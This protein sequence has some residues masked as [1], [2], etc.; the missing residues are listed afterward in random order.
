MDDVSGAGPGEKIYDYLDDID[1]GLWDDSNGNRGT[2]FNNAV[3]TN[4]GKLGKGFEFD[5][6][7]DYINILDSPS[8]DFNK[9]FTIALWVKFKGL[10]GD[11]A[12]I[13]KWIGGGDQRSWSFWND[14]ANE[15]ELRFLANEDGG[16]FGFYQIA[17]TNADL[18]NNTWYH[19]AVTWNLTETLLY[20][21][22]VELITSET[23]TRPSSL[24]VSIANV[25]IAGTELGYSNNLNS[26][27]DDVM[28]FNRSLSPA[29]IQALYADNVVKNYLNDFQN[30]VDG[31]YRFNAYAQDLAGNIG[32]ETER[33]VTIDTISPTTIINS[34][35]ASSIQN[36]DFDV[37][38]TD[39]D[40]IG[41]SGID[42]N[43]CYYRILDDG[44][45]SLGWTTRTCSGLLTI[46]INSYCTTLGIDTCVVEAYAKDNAGNGGVG[47]NDVSRSFSIDTSGDIID[48]IVVFNDLI[49]PLDNTII[50][51]S[52]F[53]V[54][55]DI[56]EVSLD[57]V[58]YS[59]DGIDYTVFNDSLV[60]M[61]N[62]DNVVSLG[63]SSSNVAELSGNGIDLSC[64]VCPIA[65]TGKFN[66]CY[67]YNG[68]INKRY[69]RTANID[70][71]DNF[72]AGT[73]S[74]WI[75]TTKTGFSTILEYGNPSVNNGFIHWAIND[76]GT[77]YQEW[78]GD[79]G[80][81]NN[82]HAD[83]TKP[84]AFIVDGK[85]HHI[86]FVADGIN[87]IKMYVDGLEISVNDLTANGVP[88]GTDSDWIADA[89]NVDSI[90]N[91]IEIGAFHYNSVSF[92]YFDGSI[93]EVRMYDRALSDSEIEVLYK[94]NLNKY[95]TDKWTFFINQDFGLTEGSHTFN[96]YA[97]DVA[98][99]LGSETERTI[100][101][102]TQS[103]VVNFQGLTPA[104]GFS[105]QNDNFVVDVNADDTG[106]GDNFIS[107]FINFDKSLVGWWRMDDVDGGGNPLDYTNNNDGTAYGDAVQTND[108][109]LGKGFDFDGT[110]DY[111]G[112]ADID[113]PTG[114]FSI[115]VWFKKV[116]P[117]GLIITKGISSVNQIFLHVT[118]LG[119]TGGVYD[120]SDWA[121]V[122]DNTISWSDGTWHHA[123]LV[124]DETNVIM[125]GDGLFLG[126]DSHDNS[127]PVND[128]VWEIG[129]RNFAGTVYF[130]G[131]IDD[132][133]IFNRSLS[134]A[135][136]QALYANNT[137]KNYLNDFQNLEIGEHKFNAYAQDLAGN[138]GSEIERTVNIGTPISDCAELQDMQNGLSDN[139]F[140]VNNIDCSATSSWNGGLGFDPIGNMGEGNAF[141]GVFDG[142]GY[143]I[144]GL[145]INRPTE[146]YVGLF[147]V[148]RSVSEIK[149][150]GLE[151]VDITGNI[152]VGG[153]VGYSFGDVINSSY[154]K[155]SVNGN[156]PGVGGLAGGLVV[157]GIVDNCYADV[158]VD[159]T[160][161]LVGGLIGLF[162][163]ELIHSYSIS[164]VTGND[165]VGVLVG[166]N[167]GTV[168]D[169]YYPNDDAGVTCS[170]TT[171]CNTD[172]ATTQ[173]NLQSKTWLEGNNWGFDSVTG[174]WQEV[175]GD[176]KR[177]IWEVVSQVPVILDIENVVTVAPGEY[178]GGGY[179][180]TNLNGV[181]F[182]VY[183]ADGINDL[184]DTGSIITSGY[185]ENDLN[186]PYDYDS[187]TQPGRTQRSFSNLDCSV[188]NDFDGTAY[189][190][191]G[192]LVRNY[193]CNVGMYYYD[194]P[195]AWDVY[196][197]DF[198][199]VNG[200]NAVPY[201]EVDVFTIGSRQGL[202]FETA[203]V[204]FTG[205]SYGN[206]PVT[207]NALV[208]RN[209]GN[210]NVDGLTAPTTFDFLGR[211]LTGET[212]TT[213][214]ISAENFNAYL[215]PQRADC[216]NAP[217][218]ISLADKISNPSGVDFSALTLPNGD[219]GIGDA[220]ES[221][222]FC[223]TNLDAGLSI[224]QYSTT[225]TEITYGQGSWEI[226]YFILSIIKF[227]NLN[228]V[229]LLVIGIRIK[230]RKKKKDKK[231]NLSE[232][233]L[234]ILNK[235]L[236]ERYNIG[237]EELLK[238]E[239]KEKEELQIPIAIFNQNISPA[240]VLSKY[241]KE[242]L[243]LNFRE[244]GK[245]INRD[246]RTIWIN[247]R[248]A[249]KK[250]KLKIKIKKKL[251]IEKL[252][253]I[254]VKIFSDRRLSVL[255]SIVKYL[256]EREFRNSEIAEM[257]GKDPRNIYTL[258]SR[259]KKK[260]R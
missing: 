191:P 173:S 22:G 30:L 222:Y 245:L 152:Y 169:S 225:Q 163:T 121:E 104:N 58:N 250:K 195:I 70:S 199:D 42:S 24:Y 1:N 61:Y 120:G 33:T 85:W 197:T 56:E 16:P 210:T 101:I 60:L 43:E 201:S 255:E 256:K 237:I 96:V 149:N 19:V 130:E 124:I 214:L 4:D 143:I 34:P 106:K 86:A 160:D 206:I 217:T 186:T 118:G 249:I 81:W 46:I 62:F 177:L 20:K 116:G 147:G 50:L 166:W 64:T 15:K 259:V 207:S 175:V 254:S 253:N 80:V 133:M 29:E 44:V 246:E 155:G 125:Y 40:N 240:E 87:K 48:P 45:Q 258:Y 112:I 74:A 59:F 211:D 10:L 141:T 13:S 229:S 221:I 165:Q 148:I 128:A 17:S 226:I 242:N 180:P 99:N 231:Y 53:D 218:F 238:F 189:G 224:Q 260:L 257:L 52:S 12:I 135:E 69:W 136:V 157:N 123:T 105:Q 252:I 65:G 26:T 227:I 95:D 215:S 131:S 93:D 219:L 109:K 223:L 178:T 25:T 200:A 11:D 73:V 184:P 117:G 57:E 140:L 142:K 153:L 97:S 79:S 168:T 158:N 127:F 212:T 47:I 235:K 150:L 77:M 71:Y 139:Y 213:E 187:A 98:G 185:V 76:A 183:D 170:A 188:V 202:S 144:S 204:S 108:G 27:I 14:W 198:E 220:E 134:P 35:E 115:S 91:Y 3:Q 5:G 232:N 179:T 159:G 239:E 114:G 119:L 63:E 90:D 38:F 21:N 161:D 164:R 103:P 41:G 6:I 167:L 129:R 72:E 28:I 126:I 32:S 84:E 196:I 113:F 37:S 78:V 241:L 23:G 216:D 67:D 176:Y 82:L 234:L 194:D 66:G 122:I 31:E 75:K 111:I 174:P 208:L 94:S 68:G 88:D 151:D 83:W 145:Y 51:T 193:S 236:K 172:G 233:D 138:I 146:S 9:T 49:T 18:Q 244:I 154:V 102:D 132:V 89:S 36:S 92:N 171:S 230:K 8:L 190:Y 39:S 182:I 181:R 7:D 55:A 205:V 192:E 248:N 107:S 100:K 203:S 156:G 247:Y 54:E 2:I 243:G 209:T 162:E 251:K 110:G 137:V 228:L